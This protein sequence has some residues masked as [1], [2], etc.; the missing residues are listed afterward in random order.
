[1]NITLKINNLPSFSEHLDT[2]YGERGTEKREQYEQEYEAFPVR[3]G[4]RTDRQYVPMRRPAYQPG[5]N[6]HTVSYDQ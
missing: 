5:K 3:S 4:L 6:I 1:M 2:Q